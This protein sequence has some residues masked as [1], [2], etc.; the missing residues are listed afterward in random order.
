MSLKHIFCLLIASGSF[1]A[2]CPGAT[3]TV[4]TTA[5]SGPGSLRQ[6]MLNANA[7]TSPDLAS[8][9][10]N[11]PGAGVQSVAPL[12]DLPTVTRPVT[13]DGYAQPGASPNTLAVGSDAVLL[14]QLTGTNIPGATG[15]QFGVGADG[16]VVRGLVVNRFGYGLGL[17]SAQSVV[18]EGCFIGTDATGTNAQPNDI[19]VAISSGSG[20]QLGGSLPAARNVV[21]GSTP[22]YGI[23]ITGTASNNLVIGNYIGLGADGVTPVPNGA[24]IY[25]AGSGSGN[26]IGGFTS[27]DRNVISANGDGCY[28]NSEG[29]NFFQGNFIGTDASGALNR[30]N[31]VGITLIGHGSVIGGTNAG[32]GNLISGRNGTGVLLNG[33][34]NVVA[35]NLIGTD[36]TG[37]LA[38]GN[39]FDGLLIYGASNVVG[40]TVT[41]ARN[42]IAANRNAVYFVNPAASG[43]RI[44]GNFIGTDITGTKAIGNAVGVLAYAAP[45]NFI[46]G[47]SAG[48]GNVISGNTNGAIFLLEPIS[49]NYIIQ[50][51]S[52]G[53]DASG[54]V[55]VPNGQG[56]YVGSGGN[57]IG[58]TSAAAG[59]FISAN[60]GFGVS[61]D[62][63]S[64]A[65]NNTVLGNSSFGNGG[66]GID[67]GGNGATPNDLADADDGPNHFQNFPEIASAKLAAGD[68]TVR[69]RVDSAIGNSTYPLTVEF[70][71]ADPGGEGRTFLQRHT[72]HTP[73]AFTN[74]TFTP[75]TPVNES[76]LTVATATDANGNTSE[77]SAQTSVTVNH[78]PVVLN[79]V[80]DQSA[81]YGSTFN[82]TFPANAFNDSDAGDTLNYSASGLPPGI[83]LTPATRTFSGASTNAGI[84]SVTVTATDD[85]LPPL[86]ANDVFDIAVAK[87][88]LLVTAYNKSKL[89][90]QANPP[91]DGALIGVTNN[92]NIT[93]TFETTATPASPPGNYPISPVFSDPD[94][95]LSNYAI[96]TNR[97]TLTVVDCSSFAINN[98]TVPN[99]ARGATYSVT[100]TAINGSAPYTFAVTSG[101]LPGNLSLASGGLLSGTA[102]NTGVFSFTITTTDAL[103]CMV[104]SNYNLTVVCPAITVNPGSLPGAIRGTA[105]YQTLS[106]SG[107]TA[108]YA[109]AVSSG[110]LPDGVS[111]SSSGA[112]TGTPTTI[113]G[114]LFI[115][116][117]T[118]AGGCTGSR[119]YSINVACPTLTVLPFNLSDGAKGLA[120]SATFTT[121]NGIAPYVYARSGGALPGGVT[122][123][124]TGVLSG[125][126]TNT[127]FY[128]FT[129][130]STD[131]G[132]CTATRSYTMIV[133]IPQPNR[134][135]G[136]GTVNLWNFTASNW[137][138]GLFQNDEEVLFDDSGSNNVPVNLTTLVGPATIAVNAMKQY[139]FAGGGGITGTGSL[140][141]A[142][143]GELVLSGSNSY[144]GLTRILGGTV[145]VQHNN[146]LG[147]AAGGTV[148]EGVDAGVRLQGNGLTVAEP[149]TIDVPNSLDYSLTNGALINVEHT[150]IW[151]GPITIARANLD[152]PVAIRPLA[153]KLILNSTNPIAGPGHLNIRGDGDLVIES[154]IANNVGSLYAV[155]AGTYTLTGTNA[156]SGNLSIAAGGRMILKPWSLGS[157]SLFTQSGTTLEVNA[158]GGNAV[159]NNW[160][161]PIGGKFRVSGGTVS[162]NGLIELNLLYG[163]TFETADASDR[164]VFNSAVRHS[165]SGSGFPGTVYIS[166]P[167]TVTFNAGVSVF[168]NGW[169][170]DW[171]IVSSTVILNHT[172]A[173][174][175][176][177]VGLLSANL[178]TTVNGGTYYSFQ[179]SSSGN[180]TFRPGRSSM[181]AGV[182]NFFDT[183]WLGQLTVSPGSNLV[184]SSTA[185]VGFG[186]AGLGGDAWLSIEN[187]GGINARVTVMGG[188]L[189]DNRGYALTKAGSGTLVLAGNSFYGGGTVVSNGMLRVSNPSGSATGPGSVAVHAGATLGGAG[190][191]A[192]PVTVLAG[193]TL[194]PGDSIGTLVISNHLTLEA[195]ATNAM[196]VNVAALNNDKIVGLSNVTYGGTLALTRLG[197][198]PFVNGHAIKLFDAAS[199]SGGFANI[200]PPAPGA[201]LQWDTRTLAVDGTLR[202][203]TAAAPVPFALGNFTI[204][205]GGTFQFAFTNTPAATFTV[206]AATNL[207]LPLSNWTVLGPVTEIL[208]GQFHF[209]DLQATNHTQRF[210]RVSSP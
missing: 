98:A 147:T 103:G 170:G 202:V 107:G 123:N 111:L 32:A 41:S 128:N 200:Q 40:G 30:G 45:A 79:P 108:P 6:A 81:L 43:N 39:E 159:V 74:I 29:G 92:D 137:S 27:G 168:Q 86:S 28:D 50:G 60:I 197:A 105:Y 94:T 31:S 20:H 165:G 166:G 118:D 154:G 64:Y 4:T 25:L 19:G 201:G 83:V 93:V 185:E 125:T 55:P 73:Q 75:L 131:A 112:L 76:H 204:L 198:M 110:A 209:A 164:L 37:Q 49:T 206:L 36:L 134:W 52:I 1:L 26:R 156:S 67:L 35:G 66:L 188:V 117:S 205:P 109:F 58:G 87:A 207:T 42:V 191:I 102:T 194:A 180:S 97:G 101:A 23:W 70:F 56:I 99:A 120:Y 69:Y 62:S 169:L 163:C 195:A 71:L 129:I 78:A 141:K 9:E 63:Y 57:L 59:N 8:I 179:L 148:V 138:R 135:V 132:G 152:G 22:A 208:P 46:G 115:V 44:I 34:G 100:V 88:P 15:L 33:T 172:N 175:Q 174:S 144:S 126:P 13:I 84:Y 181:G 133:E 182:S 72:Y 11:I 140:S 119:T 184:A 161:R 158:S 196:E 77:F 21:C 121:T 189:D 210:Y 190:Q 61:M 151:S 130:S 160:F 96:T 171:T 150:N 176:R 18:V 122:L 2:S 124:P 203:A 17:N 192:G 38:L 80:P 91:L 53:T 157:G 155:G 173:L 127:G 10:F 183:L 14:V 7:D 177:A 113:G 89:Q 82:Y 142:N 16:S 24:G 68:L 114:S 149:L 186:E 199:Y 47:A 12:T 65:T 85:G 193:G 116:T 162:H 104:S 5:D 146:A 54:N 145:T 153:G 143:S 3:F 106:A 178:E 187:Q 51:N 167:G 48:E 136:D 90:G 95:R 139:V